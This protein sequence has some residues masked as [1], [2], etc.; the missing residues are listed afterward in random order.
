MKTYISPAN[1]EIGVVNSAV[2]VINRIEIPAA[3]PNELDRLCER[4][5]ELAISYP[6]DY[7]N[8]HPIIL[9]L[10]SIHRDL[11]Y[12][13]SDIK[14]SAL[15]LLQQIRKRRSFPRVNTAVDCY[16]IVVVQKLL[17]IGAHDLA[18]IDG[19]VIFSLANGQERFVPLGSSKVVEVQSGDFIYRDNHKVLARLAAFDCDE[20]KIRPSTTDLLLVIEGNTHVSLSYVWEALEAACTLITRF[21][22]GLYSITCPELLPS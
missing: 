11:G 17:G 8:G 6:E 4:A 2:A 10:T 20:A 5:V 19:P 15:S 7:L 16:N 12:K 9:G 14:P 18:R 1:L 13:Y 3:A 22:G 21:C